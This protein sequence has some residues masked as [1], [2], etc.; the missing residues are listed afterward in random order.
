M[1]R[2]PAAAVQIH[3]ATKFLLFLCDFPRVNMSKGLR[4]DD[5]GEL[6]WCCLQLS[7]KA[8]GSS[9]RS[10]SVHCHRG[11]S[12]FIVSNATNYISWILTETSL[13]WKTAGPSI[14]RIVCFHGNQES[15]L[16]IN[17]E[18]KEWIV[19]PKVTLASMS[20]DFSLCLRKLKLFRV[21]S[22]RGRLFINISKSY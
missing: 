9:G 6:A 1:Q 4:A 21:R 8:K 3:G 16:L 7:L 10:V 15:V 2:W 5:K 22:P 11:H 12:E 18:I 17:P 19:W 14:F 13:H 20:V